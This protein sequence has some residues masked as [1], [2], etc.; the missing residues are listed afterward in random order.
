ML[1]LKFDYG[2]CVARSEQVE[3]TLDD[4]ME[5]GQPLD[6]TRPFLPAALVGHL[7]DVPGLDDA[8][9]LHLN[10]IAGNAYLNLFQFVEEYI[11]ATMLEHA[12]AELFGNPQA[13]RALTRMVDEELKHQELFKRFRRSFDRDFGHPCGVLESA[14]EVAHVIMSHSPIAVMIITLHIEWMTQQHYTESVRRD[15]T[16]DPFFKSLLRHHWLEE[17]QHAR[18][19]MLELDKLACMASEEMRDKAVEEY[20]GILDAFDDLLGEQVELDLASLAAARGVAL[21]PAT[22]KA[23]EKALHQCYRHTFIW[24]GM[25]NRNV[26]ESLEKISPKGAAAVAARAERFA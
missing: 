24:Y 21:E 7:A 11:L 1:D 12:Q 16:I 19:D 2:D 25:T 26:V 23:V 22:K 6:F 14:A 9:R 20:L 5:E 15:D 8:T 10:Q 3:W 18:I 13:M 4:V 17:S